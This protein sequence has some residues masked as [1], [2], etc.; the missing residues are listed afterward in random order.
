MYKLT[1]LLL[2]VLAGNTQ[3]GGEAVPDEAFFI[4][5]VKERYAAPFRA[6]DIE[7][8]LDAFAEPAIALH[9]RRPMDRGKASIG[10]FGRAVKEYFE[11]RQFDVR[12][13]DVRRSTDWVYTAGEYTTHFVNKSDGVAPW[14]VEEGKFLL[15]W[16]RQADN[17][18]KIIL[19]TGN[20][21]QP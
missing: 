20:A 18:W 16:E 8:W 15:L 11:L 6:G 13:T 5:L 1:G 21:N 19:D 14:G 4:D 2:F 3:A 17:S 10:A 7:A 12:V 9:N